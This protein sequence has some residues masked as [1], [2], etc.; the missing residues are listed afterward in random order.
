MT[1]AHDYLQT[2]GQLPR[3]QHEEE[4][5][6]LW[7]QAMAT[8]SRAAIVHAPV[9]LEGLDQALLLSAVR[10]ALDA[11]LVD[12]VDWLSGPAAAAALYELAAAL[13]I[14][15]ERRELGRRVLTRLYEGDAETFI[16]LATAL[17][18]ESRR[19]LTGT[20]IRARVALA[21]ELPI[22]AGATADRLALALISQPD[23][24][25][26]W[27]LDP[28]TGSLPS[29]RLAARLLERA[30]RESARLASEGDE[31]SLRVFADPEV[32]SAWDRLLL[33]RESLVWRHVATARGLLAD[34]VPDLSEQIEQ[35]LEPNLT[36]TEWRRAGVSMAA[37]IATSPTASLQRCRQL[38][39][40]ESLRRDAGLAATL[41]FGLA[42]AAESEPEAA[43][44]LLNL[45]VRA[46][47][48]DAAEALVDL[49]RERI[50][51]G[52]GAAASQY[53][54]N[55]L[56][57]MLSAPDADDGRRALCESLFE[58]LAPENERKRT[59]LRDRLDAALLAWAESNARRAY[60]EAQQVFQ[61]AL[62]QV[63]EL[64]QARDDHPD[65]RR[66]AF[67]VLR[68]LDL[69]MLETAAL[70]DLL[71]I[72]SVG[73]GTAGAA[74]PLGDVFER[75]T[76]WL[77]RHE[78][79]AVTGSGAIDHLTYRLRR[80]RTLLHV[81][82]A[83]GSYGDDTTGQRRD[84]RLRTF[85]ALLKRVEADASSPLRRVVC[86]S[87]ART[88]DAL[89]RDEICELSDVFIAVADHVRSA[90]DLATLAEASMDPDFG[91]TIAGYVKLMNGTHTGVQTGHGTRAALEAL[92]DFA[93]ALPWAATLRVNALR[94]GLLQL[95]RNLETIAAARSLPDLG[96]GGEGNLIARL[97]PTVYGLAQLTAGARR[98]ILNDDQSDPPASGG[99]ITFLDLAVERKQRDHT[100]SLE[101]ALE[102]VTRTLHR[103]LPDAVAEVVL[104]VMQRL[105]MLSMFEASLGGVSVLPPAHTDA[106]LPA[107][108]PPR[109]TLGG[110][111]VLRP[112]GA[113]GVGT[114]FV[115]KRAEERHQ[116]NSETFAL[117]VPDY[118]AAAARTLSEDEFLDL[119]RQEA[120]ALLAIPDHPN[121]ASFV[122]FDARAKPK[123]ILVMRL[124][125]GATLE[126]A[127]EGGDL[128]VSHAC[129][130]LDGIGAGLEQMH[131]VGLGHLDVKPSNV[132]LKTPAFGQSG[133][134][135]PVLVDFGLAGRH[136][137]PGCAT[138]AYGAPEIWGL[139]PPNHTPR[140]MAAD[141][142]AFA[143]VV[144]ETLTGDVLFDEPG[145]IATINAHL[146]HDGHPPRLLTLAT[147]PRLHAL[148]E[149]IANGLRQHP[150]GRI[151]I[152]EMRDG[153]RE[154]RGGLS[155]FP[156]PLVG[157]EPTA[158]TRVRP[159]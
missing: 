18:A 71:L 29:R 82:D 153:L 80:P 79:V 85:R 36:P 105:P 143:C 92:K 97:E 158:V 72:G 13:P 156:W 115:V 4:R 20:P 148:C 151:T 31:G 150:A 81:V 78:S 118:D 137:R 84:R 48:I 66:S 152:E 139:V 96:S 135:T 24:R 32:R 141:A 111:Y 40:D 23:L 26:E 120:G 117:K 59:S 69:A 98:R 149:L 114:V 124:V 51:A 6:S 61:I 67:R 109:R 21:L 55:R 22:G 86:A 39:I 1:A 126:R 57:K 90:H 107:W 75:L 110:F 47:G 49:K 155:S 64:E 19:T 102:L 123:P 33:D 132:I 27:L 108:L 125:A 58:E 63:A 159:F 3:T 99:A 12:D 154:L 83:D 11:G 34:S 138:A 103:E 28:S 9:P 129:D 14:G 94:S 8:L 38:L 56:Q 116:P 101:D 42:R 41:I 127:I 88:A 25:R 60:S 54:C 136:I 91:P 134:I 5:R 87:L 68:E 77:L 76:R 140:P 131:D 30:A 44:E 128:S 43:E 121:L 93:Q 73:K 15:P 112:L 146:N 45:I 89:V 104:I 17:A 37:R 70:C 46:G 35:H 145:E 122:T 10:V 113:G 157:N 2:F 16:T 62:S 142:Y 119:F 100:Q 130:L 106:P 50:G 65:G 144:Y 133:G 7:R 74:A 147:E 52:F 53:A 95:A